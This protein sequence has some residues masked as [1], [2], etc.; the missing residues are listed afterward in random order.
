M[1][2][3]ERRGTKRNDDDDDSNDDDDDEAKEQL[4]HFSTKHV[5]YTRVALLQQKLIIINNY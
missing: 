2:L 5:C 1:F 3:M 4:H